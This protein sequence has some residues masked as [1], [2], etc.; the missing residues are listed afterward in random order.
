MES[1][2]DVESASEIEGALVRNP[3]QNRYNHLK[4]PSLSP[5]PFTQMPRRQLAKLGGNVFATASWWNDESNAEETK[6]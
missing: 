4:P 2:S 6:N 1:P 3:N 5:P